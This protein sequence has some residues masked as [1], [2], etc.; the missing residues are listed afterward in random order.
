MFT[1]EV[2]LSQFLLESQKLTQNI[3]NRVSQVVVAVAEQ[4]VYQWQDKVLKARLWQGEKTPYFASISWQMVGELAADVISS[5]PL[6][7]EIESGRPTRDLKMMIATSKKT[8]VTKKGIKYLI[9]PFRHNVP[10]P[11]GQGALAPQ[12]PSDIYKLAKQLMPSRVLPLGSKKPATRLSASGFAVPQ[13]SYQWG[14]RLPA[15]LAPKKSPQ[16]VTDIYAGM[17]KMNTS[18]GKGKSSAYMTFRTM[19]ENSSGWIVPAKPGLYIARGVTDNLEPIFK[20]MVRVAV[21]KG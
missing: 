6:A 19:K 12:M 5:Y 7:E 11:S 4:A 14:G 16:H 8:R 3:K 15:G 13:Q 10:T 17:V 9:I 1:M 18:A 2:D 21:S 20:D